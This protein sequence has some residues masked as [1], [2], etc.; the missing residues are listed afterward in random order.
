[1]NLWTISR[2]GAYGPIQQYNQDLSNHEMYEVYFV[3][4]TV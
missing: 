1:M 3:A 4:Y 2:T